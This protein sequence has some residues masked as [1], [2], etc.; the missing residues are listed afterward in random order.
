VENNLVSIIMPVYNANGFIDNSIKSV[1]N[2]TY[3]NWELLIIDDC[4]TDGSSEIAY[5]YSCIYENIKYYKHEKNEGVAVARNTGIENA[6]GKYIAFL[7]S[8]D[9]WDFEKLEKQIK[10]MEDNNYYFTYTSYEM[11]DK[12]GDQ[13]HKVIK[14]PKKLDYRKLLKGNN[15]GCFTVVINKEEIDF[16]S[17]PKIKHED[18]AAWLKILKTGYIAYGLNEKLGFYRITDD[19]ITSNKFSSAIWTWNIY[20]RYLNFSL[21]KSSYYFGFYILN[22]INKHIL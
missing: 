17:M 6:E 8:D 3:K 14:P 20:R 10:F 5:E 1:I 4:S 7:D 11:V 21:L 19:G 22:S 12:K 13:L 15:I 16:I 9:F 18:Y 2:Q